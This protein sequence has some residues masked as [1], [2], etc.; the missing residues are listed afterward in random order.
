M[1]LDM[2][3]PPRCPICHDIIE[4]GYTLVCNSCVARLPLFSEYCCKKCGKPVTEGVE[5][6]HDC[7]ENEHEYT[8]GISVFLYEDIMR[9]SIA[10]FKYSGRREYGQFYAESIWKFRGQQL[11]EWNPEVIVPVP[12][13]GSKRAIRGYNQAEVIA[14]ELGRRMKLPV[15]SKAVIRSGKTRAQKELTPEERKKNLQ[16]A[17]QRGKNPFPWKRVLLIDDIYTTGSTVDAVSHILKQLGATQIYVVS[18]CIGKGI[19]V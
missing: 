18:V 12:I 3:Y 16:N 5:Y 1:I 9:A 19:V 14:N 6:C 8:R 17:F 13:H 15:V 10:H 4:P 11:S 7:M 2:I